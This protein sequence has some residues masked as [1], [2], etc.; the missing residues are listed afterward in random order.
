MTGLLIAKVRALTTAKDSNYPRHLLS[1][2]HFYTHDTDS[3]TCI[4][5]TLLS[6]IPRNVYC[7]LSCL[8]FRE[9]YIVHSLV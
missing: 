5:Y 1:P 3:E 9:K 4:L 2:Y 6:R 8:G 7:T